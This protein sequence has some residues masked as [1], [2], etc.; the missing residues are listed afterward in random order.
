VQRLI[1]AVVLAALVVVPGTRVVRN[2]EQLNVRMTG[3]GPAVTIEHL[4]S[5]CHGRGS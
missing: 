4:E 5:T 1:A 3:D 2:R